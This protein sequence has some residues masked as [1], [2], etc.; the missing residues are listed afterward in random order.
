M[1]DLSTKFWETAYLQHIGR[2]A[3]ICYR[4]TGNLQVSEDLA[5]DAF[6]VAIDK[7]A[8]F[9]GRGPFE[10]WL[11]KITV[12]VALQYLREQKRKQYHYEQI[13]HMAIRQTDQEGVSRERNSF[14]EE[15][16]L[17]VIN[18]LPEHHRLVFNLFVID[19]CTHAHIS[20]EL[21]ISEGTSKS[22]LA[23]ARKKI[24]ILL[25]NK[26]AQEKKKER[27][28]Y[29]FFIVFGWPR[30]SVDRL[31]FR[32]FYHLE[33]QPFHLKWSGSFDFSGKPVPLFRAS[34]FN[35]VF[36]STGLAAGLLIAGFVF[37]MKQ[38]PA[39]SN[40]DHTMVPATFPE[41][42]NTSA[43]NDFRSSDSGT[44]LDIPDSMGTRNTMFSDS[45]GATFSDGSIIRENNQKTENMKKL[46]MIG[47]LLLTGAG[48]FPDSMAQTAEKPGIYFSKD[49]FIALSGG[50]EMPVLNDSP[51]DQNKSGTFFAS[52]FTWSGAGNKL[53][54]K[55]KTIVNFG[56]NSFIGNGTFTFMEKVHY[57]VFEGSP[58]EINS[59]IRLK[60]KKYVIRQLSSGTARKKYGDKGNQG[61]VEIELAPE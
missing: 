2:M 29:A 46:N 61:A 52:S 38:N 30:W 47:A 48:I 35:G 49:Q 59:S 32:Q 19:K 40:A 25:E 20:R 58:V 50:A 42:Y 21:G 6:L 14:S 57:L 13:D 4:Y 28:K 36:L 17:N 18:S 45:S 11:R 44:D 15:E 53:Y 10:A 33:I 27:K 22:H 31:F 54:L 56:E 34:V 16:L 26:L 41:Q 9:E 60:E 1:I 39:E 12:N 24:R 7:S 23:R 43:E 8:G 3:G 51:A 5:H 37:T 55:G